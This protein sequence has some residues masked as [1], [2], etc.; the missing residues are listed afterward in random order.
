ML[1]NFG[2]GEFFFLAMLA[3]L[4]FGPER[5]PRIGASLGRWVSNLTGYSKAFLT[6]WRE[7]ALAIHDA[8]EEVRG[9]RDE[10]AAASAE[11]SSTLDVAREDMSEGLGAAK[12]AVSGARL[13]VVQRVAN[14]QEEALTDL[15]TIAK[16]EE[17]ETESDLGEEEAIGKTQQ[18][19][20]D[21]RKKLEAANAVSGDDGADAASSDDGADA[22]SSDDSADAISGD[23]SADAVSGDDSADAASGD[24]EASEPDQGSPES[25]EGASQI[26]EAT[27]DL[28]AQEGESEADTTES[29]PE[30]IKAEDM[31]P[32]PKETAFDRTQKILDDL[33]KRRSAKAQTESAV[34]AIEPADGQDDTPTDERADEPK[35][36]TP[37]D[38]GVDEPKTDTPP[39]DPYEFERLSAQV[40]QLQAEIVALRG[41]LQ[42]ILTSTTQDEQAVAGEKAETS[43]NELSVE[44]AA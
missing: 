9:I 13:D 22:A 44:E 30:E 39:I 7:E 3:L 41:E 29:S 14:Q 26:D 25:V 28:P 17:K 21:L 42:T 20:A 18:I 38:E 2:L 6:E 23:D 10:L 40:D 34:K 8:V 31:P 15:D 11:L 27:A 32:P 5:L 43:P 1:D 4:F 37:S 19:L 33:V 16:K 12:D 35:T 24:D 36:D